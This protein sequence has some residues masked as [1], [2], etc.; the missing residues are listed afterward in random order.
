MPSVPH[1]AAPWSA[2]CAAARGADPA[3]IGLHVPGLAGRFAGHAGVGAG[4]I[5][6]QPIGA[7]LAGALAAVA[8]SG[9]VGQ[10]VRHRAAREVHLAGDEL[11]APD[12]DGG[13]IRQLLQAPL[14]QRRDAAEDAL[15]V[16]LVLEQEDHVLAARERGPR[17]QRAHRRRDQRR[18]RA[19]TGRTTL[20]SSS[21]TEIP[22]QLIMTRR[23]VAG[24]GEQPPTA[25]ESA[26]TTETSDVAEAD[27]PPPSA[28]VKPHGQEITQS[29]DKHATRTCAKRQIVRVER[30][31]APLA[32]AHRGRFGSA[33]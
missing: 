29:G 6:A 15:P 2:H 10:V 14:E 7:G 12:R 11:P 27:P 21:S 22:V 32:E 16:Q 24:A 20:T 18:W 30:R 4:L 28:R 17:R 26:A 8:A 5:A 33:D 23:L 13:R 1:E 19:G 25:P 31:P 3:E 9:R